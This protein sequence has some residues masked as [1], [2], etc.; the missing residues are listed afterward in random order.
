M[1]QGQPC[2]TDRSIANASECLPFTHITACRLWY[3]IPIHL[4]NSGLNPAVSKTVAKNQWSTLSKALDL[5][6]LISMALVSSFNPSRTFLRAEFGY[7]TKLFAT[8]VAWS[9]AL[10]HYHHL[11]IPTNNGFRDGLKTFLY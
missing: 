3:I 7:T 11:P 4:Q 2:Q 10:H 6:K 9:S 8:P 5:S 1:R